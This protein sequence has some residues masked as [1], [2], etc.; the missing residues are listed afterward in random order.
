[1]AQFD[2]LSDLSP[3]YAAQASWLDGSYSKLQT[4]H[5]VATSGQP[6][7]IACGA[8]LL[9]EHVRR[10]RFSPAV[11]QRLGQ[12][13]DVQGRSVF[14]ESF[15][16][17]VQRLRL[18]TH[19]HAAPEGTLMLPGEV[20][21]HVQGPKLQIQLLES[22][23]RI[24]VWESSAWATASARQQWENGVF[25]EEDTPHAPPVP[26]SLNGWRNRAKYIGGS[27]EF[28]SDA[29]ENT[30]GA[31]WPGLS[32]VEHTN[33]S[34]LAQIRRLFK[35][36][37]PLG[38]VWLTARQ[39]EAASVSHHHCRFEDEISGKQVSVQMSRFL[40]LMQPVLVKGHPALT[41]PSL[42]YLRQ[43]TWKQLE[44]FHPLDLKVFPRGWW[45]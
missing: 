5:L 23:I 8:G 43:R 16:N 2:W 40:N 21:L 4:L 15:L 30:P 9:A 26:A 11:I 6:F 37:H 41:S 18:R 10:F 7:F 14:Q 36:E 3:L 45:L 29:K 13:T 27:M 39:D 28:S 34:A 22:A 1:M 25:S 42:D 19:I 24:L 44:S 38:D 31:D 17:H 33:G 12:V 35:G 20:I 32:L